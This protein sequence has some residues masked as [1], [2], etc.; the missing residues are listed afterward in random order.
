MFR[1]IIASY[2]ILFS[3]SCLADQGITDDTILIG[4]HTDLSGPVS[5]VGKQSADGAKMRFDEFNSKR[6]DLIIKNRKK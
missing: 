1:I 2:L 6:I 5:M 3:F 4:M